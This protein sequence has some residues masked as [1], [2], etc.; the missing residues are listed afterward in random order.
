MDSL[1]IYIIQSSVSLTI[2]YVFYELLFKREAYFGFNRFYLLFSIFVSLLLPLM[3]FNAWQ[4]FSANNGDS[5]ITAPVYSLVEYTLGEVIVYGGGEEVADPTGMNGGMTFFEIVMLIYL[6]GVVFAASRFGFRLYQLSRFLGKSKVSTQSG[7]RF[8]FTEPGTPVFSFL[9]Y[10]FID[11]ELFENNG[12]AEKIVEHEKI[13]IRQKHSIDLIVAEIITIVQWFNPLA[14]LLKKSLKENHEFIADNDVIAAYPDIMAYSRLLIENSSIVKAN[15]LTHNFSYSLLKRRL[16]MIEKTKD[17]V[18]FTMK[19]VWAL[20]A[21]NLVFFACSGP[22]QKDGDLSE[23]DFYK[24]SSGT[25]HKDSVSLQA[26]MYPDDGYVV[27]L[28]FLGKERSVQLELF[29]EKGMLIKSFMGGNWGPGEYG[30]TWKPSDGEEIPPGNYSYRLTADDKKILGVFFYKTQANDNAMMG[31]DSVFTVVEQMPE[32][33]GGMEQLMNYLWNSIEYPALAKEKGIQGRVFVN[34]VVEKDGSIV[35]V[36]VLRG[37]GAGCDEE[38]VRV[39]AAMP[40]WK[41][42]TQRGK[43]VRV[44]Y[45]IP[46]KFVLNDKVNDSVYPVVEVMPEFPGG[47]KNLL[48]YIAEK[49]VYPER[50]KKNGVHGRV[51]VS[52]IVEADGRVAEAKILRGIGTGCDEEALRVVNSMPNWKAGMQKGKAVRVQYNLPIK[53]A[54]Q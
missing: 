26:V 22:V 45:N 21:L 36:K 35:N 44:S 31:T 4:L 40:I 48:S 27:F 38:A 46:I 33:P 52:F 37:I 7:L 1:L 30:A 20:L 42:G 34:F 12:E 13:H 50:A 19:L 9:N 43:A 18:R 29:N 11:R 47:R 53:F 8:V 49:I 10:V 39:V 15:I 32:Y 5:P 2:F 16:F 17:P 14:Y 6:A 23:V 24:H 51:F 25:I 28:V 3:G 41:P 54:L